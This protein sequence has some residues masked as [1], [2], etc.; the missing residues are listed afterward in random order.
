MM[1]QKSV[2]IPWR[3]VTSVVLLLLVWELAARAKLTPPLFLPPF[4]VVADQ[5]WR[6]IAD[7]SP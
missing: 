5:L 7:G 1:P 3:S 4:S 6:S 2:L